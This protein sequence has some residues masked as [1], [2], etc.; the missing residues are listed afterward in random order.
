MEI[1][2]DALREMICNAIEHRDYTGTFTQMRIWADHIELWNQG[3]LPPDYTIDTLMQDHESYPRNTLIADAFFRAGFI[4]AW[5]RGFEKIREAF[6]DEQL[7]MPTFEQ[8]RGGV[9]ATIKREK[10][11]A[12]QQQKDGASGVSG[13]SNVVSQLTE[14]QLHIIK[15]IAENPL[16]S[17]QKL[18]Q[19]AQVPYRTFQRDLAALQKQGI[20][21]REGNTS[22]KKW[23]VSDNVSDIQTDSK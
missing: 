5:G 18:A 23:I 17:V 14:R 2:E 13:A 6:K 20:V 10:F 4:E 3:T 8:V 19:V 7:Q 22:A 12:M 1:P 11:I 9:L 16:L 21:V 15:F